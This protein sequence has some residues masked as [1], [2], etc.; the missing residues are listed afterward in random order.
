MTCPDKECHKRGDGH[1]TALFGE[2]GRGGV[3]GCLTKKISWKAA[4]SFFGILLMFSGAFILYSMAGEKEQNATL[5][6]HEIQIQSIKED[7]N[8]IKE[9]LKKQITLEQLELVINRA[10]EKE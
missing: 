8:E 7:T 5:N 1:H 3:V 6:R 10:L 2:D 4:L 9:T